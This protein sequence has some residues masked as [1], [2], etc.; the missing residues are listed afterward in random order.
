[1]DRRINIL[2]L[3]IKNNIQYRPINIP[4]CDASS[5]L[6]VLKSW[7]E[8]NKIPLLQLA[9]KCVMLLAL[10]T[11][12]RPRSEIQG[13]MRSEIIKG[14]NNALLL[15]CPKHKGKGSKS[16][17]LSPY[18]EDP[19]IC[20]VRTLEKYFGLTKKHATGKFENT[21]FFI[22]SPKIKP[23]SNDTISRW[24]KST[25]QLLGSKNS[26]HGTRGVS[27]SKA[28]NSGEA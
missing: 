22:T 6:E 12:W 9:K 14:K 24:I 13:I 2:L 11:S 19:S 16:L 17:W 15:H 1:M 27:I 25:I 23:A 8:N 18:N 5:M 26:A 21:M 7:S 4:T 3:G 28:F 20:P 10:S